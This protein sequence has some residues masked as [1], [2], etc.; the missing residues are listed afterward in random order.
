MKSLNVRNKLQLQNRVLKLIIVI[1]V[2]SFGM[3][4]Y[5]GPF[6]KKAEMI[7]EEVGEI[8]NVSLQ[9]AQKI[10]SNYVNDGSTKENQACSFGLPKE[11]I[12]AAM[13]GIM[14]DS[15]IGGYRV[16]YAKDG[17]NKYLVLRALAHNGS[18]ISRSRDFQYTAVKLNSSEAG[19]YGDPCPPLCD[20][21]ESNQCT[22]E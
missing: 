17:N 13:N 7:E 22:F 5:A 14:D 10:T 4:S 19:T 8:E 3:F 12:R 1:L 9:D 18:T 6:E 2:I 15:S 16:H 11:L 20:R 21:A